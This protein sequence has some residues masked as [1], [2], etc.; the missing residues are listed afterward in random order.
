MTKTIEN[1]ADNSRADEPTSVSDAL[2]RTLASIQK[3]VEENSRQQKEELEKAG[4]S[5]EKVDA[6]AQESATMAEEVSQQE[7]DEARKNLPTKKSRGRGVAAIRIIE[8]AQ[9]KLFEEERRG[10]FTQYPVEPGTEFPSILTRVPIFVPAQRG[11][12][13]QL[14][15]DELAMNFETGWGKGRKF[16]PPLTIYDEDTLLALGA[17]RQKQ[18]HGMGQNMPLK[19][20]NPFDPEEDTVVHVLYTTISEIEEYLQ[21]S[22]GGRGHKRRLAS[23]HRLAAVTIEFSRISDPKLNSVVKRRT[24]NTKL[25]DMA[26]E[27]LSKDSC[28]Y[29]Q[30]PPVMVQWLRESYTYIDMN[31]RR[32]IPSDTGKAIHKYLAGQTNINILA[33]TLKSVTG[34][35]KPMKRFLQDLRETL[36]ILE[37]I[38]WLEYELVGNGRRYPYKLVGRRLKKSG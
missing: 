14:L 16:G 13:K 22:K 30:F 32:Q 12:A 1:G 5:E 26:T 27:E 7:T 15:D 21:N 18:L 38:G 10:K 29:I 8:Q 37:R 24:F 2:D 28:L 35:Q 31:V 36:K 23:V 6:L 9:L 4:F 3:R 11:T 19:V 33:E 34:S 17:L 25:I 20:I